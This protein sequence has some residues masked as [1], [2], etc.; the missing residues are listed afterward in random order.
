M[1]DTDEQLKEYI[2]TIALELGTIHLRMIHILGNPREFYAN[3]K[4][5]DYTN[6]IGLGGSM[7]ESLRTC[8]PDVPEDF[9]R[10]AWNDLNNRNLVNTEARTLGALLSNKGSRALEGSLTNLGKQL[11]VYITNPAK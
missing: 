7:I 5:R 8:L 9:I 10:S 3:N 6:E 11:Y 2:V 4:L 1:R